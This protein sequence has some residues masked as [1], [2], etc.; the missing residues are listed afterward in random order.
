MTRSIRPHP[1]SGFYDDLPDDENQWAQYRQTGRAPEP[2]KDKGLSWFWIVVI[3]AFL[4]L[5]PIGHAIIGFA[6]LGWAISSITNRHVDR[7]LK[8][9]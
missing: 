1:A 7:R 4:L 8:E 9:Q 3:G 5:T 2:K 6:F